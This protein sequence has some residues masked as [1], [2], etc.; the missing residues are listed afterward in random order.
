[1]QEDGLPCPVDHGSDQHAIQHGALHVLLGHG[2]NGEET[3]KH[4][5][6]GQDHGGVAGITHVGT[7]DAGGQSAEEVTHDIKRRG[8]AVALG[9]DAHIGAQAD[10]HQ[11]QA[12]GRGNAQT[13]T[14]RN[15]LHDLFPDIQHGQE[16]ED[17]ALDQ[18]DHQSGLEG[19]H[20]GHAGHGDNVP[21]DHSKEAVQT[22]TGG[23]GEGLVGQEGHCEH[24]D[25]RGDAGSQEHAV[26]Q[27]LSLG[28][29]A[30]EQIGVQGDDVGHGHE[31]GQAGNQLGLYARL[32]L[33]QME[34]LF[35]HLGR[36]LSFYFLL[37]ES[38]F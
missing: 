36:P 34:E 22:H 24:T 18:N 33:R 28:T 1:M 4:G 32:V 6:N 21:H 10:V 26:P 19:G 20:I 35:K 16:D 8:E 31:G 23:Q 13:D 25:G 9:V 12:N 17:N 3:G 30:R 11:H 14:Q 7:Q 2:H 5:N 29:K 27:V 38:L 15:G 37:P